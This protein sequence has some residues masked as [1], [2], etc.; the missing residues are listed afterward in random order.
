MLCQRP[1]F[2]MTQE[3]LWLIL[4][5]K[6]VF[7]VGKDELVLRPSTT[8]A[9]CGQMLPKLLCKYTYSLSK[10]GRIGD[11]NFPLWDILCPTFLHEGNCISN[12]SNSQCW[13]LSCFRSKQPGF[14]RLICFM[15]SIGVSLC[16]PE[17]SY[18]RHV[19]TQ[20]F[21]IF[22]FQSGSSTKKCLLDIFVSLLFFVLRQAKDR[23]S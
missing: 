10:I 15:K 7:Q 12:K 2:Q 19:F 21:H 1:G 11:L 9:S 5:P 17:V 23:K 4:G 22:C 18:Q 20:G 8:L 13:N 16:W 6:D 14:Q 3:L